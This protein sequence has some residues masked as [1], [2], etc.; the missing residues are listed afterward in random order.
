MRQDSA[1]FCSTCHK[2]HLDIRL[3][4]TAGSAASRLRQLAASG[5]SGQGAR[6]FY[7]PPRASVHGLPYAAGRVA[8]SG[9]HGGKVHS[10]RFPGANTA[11]AYVNQD[12]A[13]M[14][15]T[16]QFLKSGFLTVS[17]FAASPVEEK[18]TAMIRRSGEAPQAMTGFAVGEEAEQAATS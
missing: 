13:Q 16:V 7:Y 3:T 6:S 8:R 11:L 10:H 12:Q 9:N 18:G 1:E 2:V 14:D 15:A 17:I 5:V 4:I